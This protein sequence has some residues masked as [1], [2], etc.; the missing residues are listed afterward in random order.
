[1]HHDGGTGLLGHIF[2]R[3]KLRI[4]SPD[5]S[6]Y[7][8]PKKPKTLLKCVGLISLIFPKTY[9]QPIATPNLLRLFG[10]QVQC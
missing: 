7:L 6:K 4:Y 3:E 2:S 1:M 10:I 8:Y 9:F 5:Q